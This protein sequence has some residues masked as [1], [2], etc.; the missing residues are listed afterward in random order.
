[1]GTDV[2]S[3]G[4]GLP[5]TTRPIMIP[6]E[7][8]EGQFDDAS[9]LLRGYSSTLLDHSHSNAARACLAWLQLM[10]MSALESTFG[11]VM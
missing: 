11:L 7:I 2:V 9:P 5:S 6:E 8:T 3:A 10:S 1:M 4:V